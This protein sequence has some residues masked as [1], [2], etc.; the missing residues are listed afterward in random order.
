M[1][2]DFSLW[3]IIKQP[4]IVYK[5]T[6]KYLIIFPS[7]QLLDLKKAKKANL[8]FWYSLVSLTLNTLKIKNENNST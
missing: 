7:L 3:E 8:R 6:K 5:Q 4:K 1:I 2:N